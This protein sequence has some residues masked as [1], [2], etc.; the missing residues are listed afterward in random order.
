MALGDVDESGGKSNKKS[1]VRVWRWKDDTSKPSKVRMSWR[2]RGWILSM[3]MSS[4]SSTNGAVLMPPEEE[5][6][7]GLAFPEEDEL[8]GG[9]DGDISS[10]I[11]RVL[12]FM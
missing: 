12:P 4:L 11:K 10:A 5:S 1:P 3:F 7:G 9:E 2:I 6:G 8:G